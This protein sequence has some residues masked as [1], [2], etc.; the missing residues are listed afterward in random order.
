MV[1]ELGHPATVFG[2]VQAGLGVSVLPS[3]A[4]PLPA[5]SMLVARELVPRAERTVALVRRRERSLSPAAHAVWQLIQQLP[6]RVE[7]L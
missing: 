2:L 1:Q 5:G 6:A 3:L 7:L 4:L